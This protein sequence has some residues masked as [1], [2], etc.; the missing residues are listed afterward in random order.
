M[1]QCVEK[2]TCEECGGSDCLQTFY[3]DVKENYYA[4]CFGGCGM[5]FYKD[6]YGTDPD[7]APDIVVKSE[8][9]IYEEIQDVKS[10]KVFDEDFRG[11]PKSQWKQWSVRLL[12]SEYD[13][14]TPY[15]VAFPYSDEGPLSGWKCATLKKKAFWSLGNTKGADPFGFER[16]MKL[17]GKSLYITEGEYDAIA[18]DYCLVKAQAGKKFAREAYPVVS[19]PSGAGSVAATLKKILKRVQARGFKEIVF[20]MDGDEAGQA[21][22]KQAHALLPNM[23]KRVQMPTGCKDA[24]DALQNGKYMEL[25]SN[26]LWNAHKPPIKGVIQ[27]ADILGRIQER[28]T[29]GLSYPWDDITELTYGQRFGECSAIGGGTGCGKTVIAHELAAHNFKEHGEATFMVLLEES[30]PDTIRNVCGKLDSLPYHKPDA[31]YDMEQFMATVQSLQGKVLLWDDEGNTQQRFEIDEIISAIRF[32]VAEFGIKF[33]ALDNMTRIVDHLSAS[34]A[35][36]FINKYAS[37][38]EGLSVELGIHIDVFSHLN[39]PKF[40]ASHEEGAEVVPSQFTGSKGMMRSFPVMM[41]FQR[42]KYAPDG[43][44]SYSYTSVLKNRKFGG[45]GKV[46]TQYDQRTGRLLQNEWD[47]NNDSLVIEKKK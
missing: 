32:N 12:V 10:C 39:A 2:I 27:V 7:S 22:E 36:E 21:A 42:N 18:A 23:M 37:E 6:P 20:L 28:P 25:A 13:G 29:M 24:N 15:A 16:A 33:V 34:D 46:K 4:I 3:D 19:L 44:A 17:G 30:N 47:W 14:K 31:E 35:N 26:M 1:G 43:A 41:G 5:K 38:L 8:E 45:E 40:G 11:I 9:E